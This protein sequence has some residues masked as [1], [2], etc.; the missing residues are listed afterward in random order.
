MSAAA[1]N[2][3]KKTDKRQNICK[4][5]NAGTPIS[6]CS[7][8]FC[9]SFKTKVLCESCQSFLA[10][11][12]AVILPDDGEKSAVEECLV[13]FRT[14]YTS[15]ASPEVFHCLFRIGT[16]LYHGKQKLLFLVLTLKESINRHGLRRQHYG[17]MVVVAYMPQQFAWNVGVHN[18]LPDGRQA[19]Q[20][21][22]LKTGQFKAVAGYPVFVF[23][24]RPADKMF[25]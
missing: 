14:V 12:P 16:A 20:F 9:R 25:P 24:R 7:G 22:H 17:N 10:G 11:V 13:A 5:I 3:N 8:V 21:G 23:L 18:D 2:K 6:G 1:P 19:D 15:K 4:I